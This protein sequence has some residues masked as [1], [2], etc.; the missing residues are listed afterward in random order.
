MKIF[1]IFTELPGT[2]RNMKTIVIGAGRAYSEVALTCDLIKSK[3]LQRA[4]NL[5]RWP[6]PKP[7]PTHRILDRGG[8][9]IAE[10]RRHNTKK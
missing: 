7:K 4:F 3:H 1:C 8:I 9:S 10:Q 6:E 2:L 5:L